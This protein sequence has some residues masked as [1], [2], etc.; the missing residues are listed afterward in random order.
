[1]T[2]FASFNNSSRKNGAGSLP[3]NTRLNRIKQGTFCYKKIKKQVLTLYDDACD[4]E[5][6][7]DGATAI[8]LTTF[9]G[10]YGIIGNENIETVID[11]YKV[12]RSQTTNHTALAERQSV[13]DTTS[14]Y[15]E[16]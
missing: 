13:S 6:S 7:S 2:V 9:P 8:L 4:T 11:K 3:P 16:G 15:F 14:L 5:E 1:M 12:R 10:Y